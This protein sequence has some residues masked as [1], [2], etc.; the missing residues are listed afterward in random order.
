MSNGYS[1][2]WSA[3]DGCFCTLHK[4]KQCVLETLELSQRE[5]LVLGAKT[6]NMKQV[7]WLFVFIM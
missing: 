7:G 4:S 3:L 5:R 6:T 1:M 2:G